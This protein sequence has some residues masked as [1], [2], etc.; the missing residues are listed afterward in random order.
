MERLEAAELMHLAF[1]EPR[2]LHDER[3]KIV[4]S[5]AGK[6][7]AMAIEKLRERGERMARFIRKGQVLVS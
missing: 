7:P 3:A 1:N 2:R 4:A 5:A 6:T